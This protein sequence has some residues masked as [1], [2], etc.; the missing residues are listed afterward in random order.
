VDS[1]PHALRPRHGRR[2][3]PHRTGWVLRSWTRRDHPRPTTTQRG[4]HLLV[5]AHGRH[6]TNDLPRTPCRA[7]E[8]LLC[9]MLPRH[10]ADTPALDQRP[11]RPAGAKAAPPPGRRPSGGPG[12]GQPSCEPASAN[13]APSLPPGPMPAGDRAAHR[14]RARRPAAPN[15]GGPP[16]RATPRSS[17]ART[18]RRQRR[19]H[20]RPV[21]PETWT[22]RTP[23]H[24]TRG[25]PL[26]RLDGRPH[27]RTG[28]GGQGDD[29]LA[30]VRTS[31]RPATPAGRTDLRPG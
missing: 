28:R 11:Y 6:H 19:G 10:P 17:A 16:H 23:G 20:R 21:R 7:D 30:D 3:L 13:A 26:D 2:L 14:P 5:Q 8:H 29:G 12:H 1:A 27:G 22:H 24:R 15:R 9:P 4:H 31:S 25:R 18:A